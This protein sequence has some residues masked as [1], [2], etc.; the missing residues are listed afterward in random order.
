MTEAERKMLVEAGIDP[1]NYT[2]ED[3][4]AYADELEQE[5]A[6][7][8]AKAGGLEKLLLLCPKGDVPI[9]DQLIEQGF[10]WRDDAGNIRCHEDKMNAAIAAKLAE[11]SRFGARQ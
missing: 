7:M 5:A 3:L 4:K 11:R 2:P 10:A 9:E 1:D 6:E 8:N